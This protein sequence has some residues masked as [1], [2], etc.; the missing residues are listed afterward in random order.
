[1]GTVD[2]AGRSL[3]VAAAVGLAWGIRGDY[4][5]GIGATYPGAVLGLAWVA[6]AGCPALLPRM[7][8]IAS[9]TAA[10]IGAGGT[11]SY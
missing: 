11:M 7:P 5:H 10:G 4:G 3:F 9:L 6:V 2:R 8:V 1:M